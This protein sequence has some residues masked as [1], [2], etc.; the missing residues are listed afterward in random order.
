M[1]IFRKATGLLLGAR[2]FLL[3]PLSQATPVCDALSCLA[4]NPAF[5]DE[6]SAETR[7]RVHASASAQFS[8]SA[9]KTLLP[10]E[11]SRFEAMEA[12]SENAQLAAD[13]GVRVGHFGWSYSP[14]ESGNWRMA[15]SLDHDSFKAM[16]IGMAGS[17]DLPSEG[18]QKWSWGGAL[19]Y[20]TFLRE[21][22]TLSSENFS[23]ERQVL[24]QGRWVTARLGWVAVLT[25][26]VPISLMAVVSGVPVYR[27]MTEGQVEA[28]AVEIQTGATARLLSGA[29]GEV[30]G[31]YTISHTVRPET[32]G[33]SQSLALEGRLGQVRTTLGFSE[34]QLSYGMGMELG[35]FKLSLMTDRNDQ[36]R[37]YWLKIGW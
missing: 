30:I 17:L 18:V 37:R 23:P 26:P 2:I 34:H 19:E 32:S 25:P 20:R 16:R 7:F 15:E 5:L 24:A 13:V 10:Q 27:Q 14:R 29:W 8:R 33:A 6:D 22:W 36:D 4:T 1:S 11:F 3:S 31:Q 21:K 35:F 12:K 28:E 9:L